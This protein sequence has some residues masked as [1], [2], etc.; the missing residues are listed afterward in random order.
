MENFINYL[1]SL[2]YNYTKPAKLF[3]E[4]NNKTIKGLKKGYRTLII[5]M[6]PEKQN[7]YGKNLCPKASEGCKKACL[8]TAGRG[9]FP[10]NIKARTMKADYFIKDRAS[11][12]EQA[13]KEIKSAIKKEIRLKDKGKNLAIR[14][15][16][17]SDIPFENIPLTFEGK[18]YKNIMEIFPDIQ[19][20]DYTKVYSR[21]LKELPKNYDLTFSRSENE[22]NHIECIQALGKGFRVASVFRIK[23][24]SQLPNIIDSFKVVDGDETDLTFLHPKGVILGLKAKGRAVKEKTGF[25]IDLN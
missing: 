19:F 3:G 20:Y 18:E 10:R 25:V 1:E 7:S 15:N 12:M 4:Q 9:I 22:N 11:F 16:G 24:A 17:T 13:V 21:L 8:F 5:Y 23:E 14:M 2:N 6:S